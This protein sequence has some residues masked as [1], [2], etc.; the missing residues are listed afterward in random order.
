[1][2]VIGRVAQWR[3]AETGVLATV[4]GVACW[5]PGC[6]SLDARSCAYRDRRHQ[7]CRLASC[8]AHS[9]IF[10]GALYCRRHAGTAR[11]VTAPAGHPQNIADLDDRGP[12]LIN[13]VATDL[14]EA[15]RGLLLRT[16]RPGEQVVADGYVR[17][18]RDIVGR[19]RWERSWRIVDH[20][21]LVLKVSIYIDA[22]DDS[23]IHVRVDADDVFAAVPPWIAQRPQGEI[24]LSIDVAQRQRFYESVHRAIES[25][26][27]SR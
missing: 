8:L 18:I 5:A 21:G 23:M 14:D 1:M 12:S 17:G 11:A 2:P 24:A 15:I 19:S 27:S 13:W 10:A 4:T 16:T 9:I 6:D 3:R 25:A 26:V 7:P 20:T 22:C